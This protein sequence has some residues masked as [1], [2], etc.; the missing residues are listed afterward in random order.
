M[1]SSSSTIVPPFET[2][3]D[4]NLDPP[5]P[6]DS[7]IPTCSARPRSCINCRQR[8][9][10]CDRQH[11]CCNCIRSKLECVF[12]IGRG[13]AVKKPR[14]QSVGPLLDRLHRLESTMARLKKE[15]DLNSPSTTKEALDIP[16]SV[17]SPFLD[18]MKDSSA[19]NAGVDT[20]IENQLGRLMIDDTRSYYVSNGLWTNLGNE[21]G[22]SWS[23]FLYQLL[24]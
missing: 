24:I 17:P 6:A 8:K 12:P 7:H 11:P 10:K 21:V 19:T 5:T 2:T 14:I 4:S 23:P 3:P 15:R 18:T 13:R 9:I 16:D 20:P 22:K 1:A